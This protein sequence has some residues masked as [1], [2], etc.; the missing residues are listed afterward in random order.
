M[1]FDMGMQGVEG[2][3][4]SVRADASSGGLIFETIDG[5]G[6]GEL[7]ISSLGGDSTTLGIDSAA[8]L[9]DAGTPA[10]FVFN[11]ATGSFEGEDHALQGNAADNIFTAVNDLID[12]L[13][14]NAPAAIASTFEALDGSLAHFLDARNEAGSRVRR[15]DLAANRLSGENFQLQEM[16]SEV[17]DTDLAAAST[18][19][20]Q[21]QALFQAGIAVTAQIMRVSVLDYL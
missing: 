2:L 19:Y 12:A 9:L 4:V 7:T 6:D 10:T 16:S 3:Y 21:Q 13:Q 5:D 11:P 17:M 18:R 8:G 14:G 1:R 20:A 15:L